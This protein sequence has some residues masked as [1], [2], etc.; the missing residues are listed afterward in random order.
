MPPPRHLESI[1]PPKPHTSIPR[2]GD[3]TELQAQLLF[4]CTLYQE[5][6]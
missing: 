4:S 3:S 5:N 1:I 2:E 6:R